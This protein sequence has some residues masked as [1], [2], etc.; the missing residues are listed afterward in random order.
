[1]VGAVL[2]A[3]SITLPAFGMNKAELIDA[4]AGGAKLTKADAGRALDAILDAETAA[5]ASE[6]GKNG[7][8]LSLV[9]FG[10]FFLSQHV[11]L[12]SADCTP[13]T[14]VGFEPANAFAK[15]IAPIAMDK[16]LR[17]RVQSVDQSPTGPVVTG[18]VEKG[19]VHVGD[20]AVLQVRGMDFDVE[21]AGI[22]VGGIAVAE[23]VAGQTA[24]LLLRGID[25][26][27]IRRGMVIVQKPVSEDPGPPV[28]PCFTHTFDE[29]IIAAASKASGLPYETV[30]LVLQAAEE[31]IM[32]TVASGYAVDLG[33]FGVFYVLGEKVLS[34]MD[35]GTDLPSG[36]TKKTAKFKAGAD[37]AKTV[38]K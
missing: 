8:R 3:M 29:Q 31:T 9:G 37:L 28:S 38:N 13:V 10:T 34:I 22:S 7:D 30:M 25:K 2:L 17:F 26:K 20:T 21:I 23:A 36:G 14:V 15:L 16:G 12:D 35:P 18:P 33:G 5:L 27:D 1:M 19:S 6:A 24:S 32:E 4:I 11:P